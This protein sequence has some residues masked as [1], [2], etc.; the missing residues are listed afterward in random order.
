VNL[1]RLRAVLAELVNEVSSIGTALA[2]GPPVP[3]ATWV[4]AQAAMII[5]ASFAEHDTDQFGRVLCTKLQQDVG[6]VRFHRA[7][8][9]GEC[10]RGFSA[11]SAL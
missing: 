9:D 10:S 11:G 1:P 3:A 2:I 7:G 5:V 4:D 6:A 8:A